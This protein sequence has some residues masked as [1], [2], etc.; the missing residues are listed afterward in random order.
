MRS[1]VSMP[2]YWPS[3]RNWKRQLRPVAE[4]MAHHRPALEYPNANG[5]LYVHPE[6]DDKKL[7]KFKII[8]EI[9]NL[10][11]KRNEMLRVRTCA[12]RMADR[13]PDWIWPKCTTP[14]TPTTSSIP[15][16]WFGLENW[17]SFSGPHGFAPLPQLKFGKT[18]EEINCLRIFHAA[19][20]I[21][22]NSPQNVQDDDSLN[23]WQIDHFAINL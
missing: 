8:A 7:R 2:W 16:Q 19:N 3:K 15:S 11:I 21:R 20:R 9:L 12:I 1:C 14:V 17:S 23:W 6:N 22:L 13:R 18:Q 5:F 4:S 10:I